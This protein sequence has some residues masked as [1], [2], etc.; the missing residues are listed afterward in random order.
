VLAFILAR[1]TVFVAYALN[2]LLTLYF[3][4]LVVAAVLSWVNPDPYNPIVRFLRAVT[5]PVLNQVRRKLPF[6]YAGGID[7]SPLVVILV[8]EAIQMIVV[9]TLLRLAAQIAPGGAYVLS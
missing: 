9:P 7:F 6:V 4:V 5:D 3:W 2:G 8:I 1:F